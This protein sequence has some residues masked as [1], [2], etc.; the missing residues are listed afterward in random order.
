MEAKQELFRQWLSERKV[1]I[2]NALCNTNEIELLKLLQ[3]SLQRKY[4]KSFFFLF[5]FLLLC[6]LPSQNCFYNDIFWAGEAVVYI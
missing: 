4:L 5:F 1:I 6:V 3:T 2:V